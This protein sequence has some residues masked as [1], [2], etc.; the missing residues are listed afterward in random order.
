MIEIK[1][2]WKTDVL[3]TS[4]AESIKDALLEALKAGADLSG[5]NLSGADL[6]GA[7]LSGA[8]LSGADLRGADLRGAD[9]RGAD[10]SRADLSGADL[11]DADL[12]DAVLRDSKI[13]FDEV[14]LVE[15][16]HG[17]ILSA[18][19]DGAALEMGSWHS[20]DT[21]H[22][23]AGWAIH[24]AGDAGYE[25]ERIFGS[26]MAGALIHLKACSWMEKVPNFYATNEDAMADIK[27]CAKRELEEAAK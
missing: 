7:N 20:C 17:R 22:C 23:R 12:R 25:L 2:R 16:L 14:P 9:L 1:H 19:K 26:P 13:N 21:T 15:N 27:S 11:S 10:L 4:E 3:F 18:I 24:L 8:N 6:S 5:A